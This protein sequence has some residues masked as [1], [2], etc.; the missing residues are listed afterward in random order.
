CEPCTKK[1]HVCGQGGKCVCPS[2]TIGRECER[3]TLNSWGHEPRTGCKACNCSNSG[4]SGLQCD[5]HFG[6]CPCKVGYEGNKCDRCTF[7]YYGFPNC[8]KCLCNPAGTLD[9]E[10]RTEDCQCNE[11]GS[12]NCKISTDTISLPKK[13]MGDL[14]SSYDGYLSVSGGGGRF[15]VFLT[16]NGISLNSEVSTNELKLNEKYWTV[17]SGNIAQSCQISLSRECMLVVLQKV[18]SIVIQGQDMEIVEVLLDS[19]KPYIPYNRTSHSI[20]KCN[21]SSEYKGLSCQDPNRGF[22]RHFLTEYEAT[23]SSW[24]DKVIGVARPCDCNGRSSECDP[25]NGHCKNCSNNTAGFHCELC[26]T[27]YYQDYSGHCQPCLC[28]SEF[29]NNA[30]SCMAKKYGFACHCKIGYTGSKCEHCK[31]SYFRDPFSNKCIPC[32]CNYYGS[33]SSICTEN[34]ICEC[35]SGFYGEKC[36]Q[37]KNSRQYIKDG[38]CTPCDECTQLLFNDIDRLYKALDNFT[39]R[40]KDGLSPPW[41]LLD[42]MK[43]KYK[44]FNKT[45]NYK[46]DRVNH[47]LKTGNIS[48]LEDMVFNMAEKVHALE[49]LSAENS[50]DITQNQDKVSTFTKELKNINDDINNLVKQLTIFGKKHIDAEAAVEQANSILAEIKHQAKPRITDVEIHNQLTVDYCQRISDEVNGSYIVSNNLPYNKLDELNSKIDDIDIIATG[51]KSKTT[52]A[53]F[54][55]EKNKKS[56]NRLRKSIDELNNLSTNIE[57]NLGEFTNE[58]KNMIGKLGELRNIIAAMENFDFNN[59][60]ELDRNIYKFEEENPA[61]EEL[62]R[63]ASDHASKLRNIVDLRIGALNFTKDETEKIKTSGAYNEIVDSIA[64]AKNTANEARIILQNVLDFMYPR[65]SDSLFDKANLAHT[66]SDRLKYRIENMK[67][68]STNLNA[69]R[70]DVESFKESLI[71]SGKFNNDLNRQLQY[72][73]RLLLAESYTVIKLQETIDNS[74]RII[75]Q[76]RQ[77]EKTISELNIAVRYDLL[78]V[79]NT[80]LKARSEAKEDI[81]TAS[82]NVKDAIKRVSELLDNDI[83]KIDNFPNKDEQHK[84]ERVTSK[85]EE[86]RNKILYAKQAAESINIAMGLSNCS[87]T[88]SSP[89]YQGEL[90]RSLAITFRCANCQLFKW[91]RGG[92]NIAIQ[93]GKAIMKFMV[94]DI[95]DEISTDKEGGSKFEKTLFVQRIGSLLQMKFDNDTTWKAA[96]IGSQALIIDPTDRFEIGDGMNIQ[97]NAYIYR[98]S[99]NDNNLGLWKFSQT[100]GKCTGQQR[101]NAKE[102]EKARPFYSGRGYKKYNKTAVAAPAKFNLKFYLSTF[103]ENSLIYL[104]QESQ[105]ILASVY[106]TC[107]CCEVAWLVIEE[108]TLFLHE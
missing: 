52:D 22:Y 72:L 53:Q 18:T 76:M 26:D 93:N 66:K 13:F 107:E 92:I 12:C 65:D 74:S 59:L 46:Y 5:K 23:H 102:V 83:N 1:G 64:I 19:A 49:K 97:H 108:H 36:N 11:D 4:S 88:Y 77:I 100:N 8:R 54:Q 84:L 43:T 81:Q 25:D 27:G 79:K 55:N 21:C 7:G 47:I 90:F 50:N 95:S 75:D 101:V 60:T 70:K 35:K 32:N 10:C 45:F 24:I 29:E 106:K 85:I 34:G 87:M 3:C 48:Q 31:D 89:L 56:I 33:H 57:A 9:T 94:D 61:L 68:I 63:T 6:I 96:D 69:K 40:F 17:T 51:V 73:E 86:L 105:I 98:L 91:E 44:A 15:T 67:N 62:V 41:K 78:N 38:I 2:L 82:F 42:S 28:P 58:M 20:E 30:E 37:C 104:A 99:I 39:D 71:D 103:D 14:S 80:L 16:G